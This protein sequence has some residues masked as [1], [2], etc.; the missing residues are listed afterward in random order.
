MKNKD[1]H[2]LVV[3]AGKTIMAFKVGPL[4]EVASSL[5][6]HLEEEVGYLVEEVSYLVEEVGHLVEEVDE[7]RGQVEVEEELLQ[8]R[9]HLG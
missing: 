1:H 6:V 2:Q 8:A 5:E 7:E 9:D 3:V 4:V